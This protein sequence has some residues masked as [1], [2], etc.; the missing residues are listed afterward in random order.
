MRRNLLLA[1]LALCS[2][3]SVWAALAVEGT[4]TGGSSVAATTTLTVSYTVTAATVLLV[5]VGI[6]FNDAGT[7][8]LT[9]VT[10]VT[11]NGSAM[12]AVAGSDSDDNNFVGARWYQINSPATG[13]HDVVL[14]TT[15]NSIQRSVHIIA[16][17]DA[18]TTLGTP[19]VAT[20]TTAN[21]SVT[22][23]DTASGEIVVALSVN[24]NDSGN[25]VQANTLIYEIESL[26]NDTEH[27]SQYLATAVGANTSMTWTQTGS[28]D[29]W[30]TNGLAVAEADGGAGVAVN[31][32]SGR[33]G[34]A[35]QPVN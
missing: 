13:T 8:P 7:D 34:A 29:G 15:T 2:P 27:S 14:T 10:G 23:V 35:A 24:D 25:T 9:G 16:F 22:V 26:D 11:W 5:G 28:G 31:P 6:G 21:P 3:Q 20:G 4:P 32:I 30:A 33:G 1:L 19:S 17:T 12:T 18:S